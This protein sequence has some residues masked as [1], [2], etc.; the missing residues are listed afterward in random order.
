M[1]FARIWL[2]LNGLLFLVYGLVC[3]LDPAVP[4]GYAGMT[5]PGASA[6]TE[7][8]AMYGG[9]QAGLGAWLVWS[10]LRPDRVPTALPVLAVLTGSL[11]TGRAFGLAAHGAT[12]YNVSAVLY[13]ATVAVLAV[14][15]WR[16]VSAP[17]GPA[18]A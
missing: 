9:L 14:F 17:T 13:E 7:V 15:A 3:L 10:A 16:L 4:A 12:A 1:T 8:A 2:G 5:L 11:A 18:A 6:R